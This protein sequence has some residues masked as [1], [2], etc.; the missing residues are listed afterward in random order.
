MGGIFKITSL[1]PFALGAAYFEN[2]PTLG[3]T[4]HMNGTLFIGFAM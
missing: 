3:V 1:Q 2:I 4:L